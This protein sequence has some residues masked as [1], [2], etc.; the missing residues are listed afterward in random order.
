MFLNKKNIAY[1]AIVTAL[2]VIASPAYA[3]YNPLIRIPGLP[4]TGT[5]TLSMYLVG[6]YNFLVS[7]VGIVAVMMMII[8]GMR[9]ITAGGS[10]TALSE[11]KEIVA[12]AVYGLILA[13]FAWLIIAAINPDVLYIKQPGLNSVSLSSMACVRN[14]SNIGACTCSDGTPIGAFTSEVECNNACKTQNHCYSGADQTCISSGSVNNTKSEEFGAA[15]NY[16]Q[17]LCIDGV[18]L[19]PGGSPTCEQ[20][21]AVSNCMVAGFRVGKYSWADDEPRQFA[22]TQERAREYA[23]FTTTYANPFIFDDGCLL[24]INAA[25]YTT[26]SPIAYNIDRLMDGNYTMP[27]AGGYEAPVLVTSAPF[28][29]F[30]GY[31]Q[32]LEYAKPPNGPNTRCTRDN[33]DQSVLCPLKLKVTYA[34]GIVRYATQYIKVVKSC[35]KSG[36]GCEQDSDCCN[37]DCD[38]A[39]APDE[40]SHCD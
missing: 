18:K 35:N 23:K 11:A 5:I 34:G 20:A 16:G 29:N 33:D 8:G 28:C 38:L 40:S 36:D 10:S 26:G 12:S 22:T 27:I 32:A 17:C 2:V 39:N 31:D 24:V 19:A 21:C 6:L 15:P 25:D 13:I 1:L 3:Q 37:N 14:Y 9:Y 30:F 4:A 7:I